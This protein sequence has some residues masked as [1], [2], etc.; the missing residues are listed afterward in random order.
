MSGQI[1][2]TDSLQTIA[3]Q[4]CIFVKIGPD[5]YLAK[6]VVTGPSLDERVVVTEGLSPGDIVVGKGSFILK[7]QALLVPASLEN[8]NKK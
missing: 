7:S 4:P 3:D 6:H 5:K 2:P 1:V 8:K